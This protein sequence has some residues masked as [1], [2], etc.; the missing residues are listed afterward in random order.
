MMHYWRSPNSTREPWHTDKSNRATA[1]EAA[2]SDRHDDKSSV[3][4][5]GCKFA[6]ASHAILLCQQS[7][8]LH[9]SQNAIRRAHGPCFRIETCFRIENGFVGS[10]VTCSCILPLQ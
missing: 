9:C 6:L 1:K 7:V 8:C 5:L 2:N 3:L 4:S 10:I